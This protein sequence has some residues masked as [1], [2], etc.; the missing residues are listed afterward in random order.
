MEFGDFELGSALGTGGFGEV[1]VGTHKQTGATTA[2]KVQ[3]RDVAAAEDEARCYQI[4]AGG[5]GIPTLHAHGQEGA[6]HY[7]VVDL[8]GPSLEKVFT[9]G[10]HEEF[11]TS[12]VLVIAEQMITC[13]QFVHSMG[14]VHCD[15]K[16][17]NLLI[18]RGARSAEIYLT[19]YGVSCC[20]L[21]ASGKHL[22][23]EE[24]GHC[25]TA[26][27]S[28]IRA[29]EGLRQ[30]P[31]DDLE[32]LGYV[33]AYFMAELP[34]LH[35]QPQSPEEHQAIADAK[36]EFLRDQDVCQQLVNRA[37]RFYNAF[38]VYAGTK[39]F[40]TLAPPAELLSYLRYC[41]R[42]CYRQQPDY[43]YLRCLFMEL[44]F[45]DGIFA[46]EWVPEWVNTDTDNME[47]HSS[48]WTWSDYDQTPAAGTN[49]S[50]E[51]PGTTDYT[52]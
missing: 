52:Y 28:S 36:R 18:G 15:I 22:P 7:I 31:R 35:L 37:R 25:G 48:G 32:S 49:D 23:L 50:A 16:P 21:D 27:Y 47:D 1:F 51:Q 20:Y 5:D 3:K 45:D 2:I 13:L 14:I 6:R 17:S 40:S 19:D 4:L 42:L 33:L 29:H 9:K 30:Y 34:W 43:D 11:T 46:H 41:R 12:T 24:E 39:G 26:T 10:F 44:R 8:L 38:E